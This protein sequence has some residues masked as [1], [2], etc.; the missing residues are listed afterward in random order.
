[1]DVC[2]K[3]VTCGGVGTA[4]E[5]SRGWKRMEP[6]RTM[7]RNF[8]AHFLLG[9]AN[10]NLH[11]YLIASLPRIPISSV[12]SVHCI[13][14][15]SVLTHIRSL[16][17]QRA[18]ASRARSSV[19]NQSSKLRATSFNLQQQRFS[20]KVRPLTLCIYRKHLWTQLTIHTG[21][22]VR[23][24]RPRS[25]AHRRRDTR[26][27]RRH[28]PRSQGPQCPHRVELRLTQDYKGS[29]SSPSSHLTSA[30]N[31]RWCNRRKS[32]HAQG[33]VREPGCPP[34]PG[35]CLQDQRGRW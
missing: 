32:H 3:V 22:Q 2:P 11:A 34:A 21:A 35:C 5:R 29:V 6:A 33:Q 24:R 8:L 23:R 12:S 10:S 30:H 19:L 13:Q 28:N 4:S 18:F 15:S 17:M 1:M 26:Q 7:S 20:H 27:G 31:P 25:S 16:T 14:W 9:D